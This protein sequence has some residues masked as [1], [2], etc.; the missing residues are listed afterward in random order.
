MKRRCVHA[1]SR[2]FFWTALLVTL[3][4]GF[5]PVFWVHSG[6]VIAGIDTPPTVDYSVLWKT[7]QNTWDPAPNGGLS[8]FVGYGMFMPYLLLGAV[9]QHVGLTTHGISTGALCFVFGAGALGMVLLAR[10]AGFLVAGLLGIAYTLNFA[11]TFL[12]PG[13]GAFLSY[14]FLPWP[15]VAAT[16]AAGRARL[17]QIAIGLVAGIGTLFLLYAKINP[18]T[19]VATWLGAALIV[20]VTLRARGGRAPW[21]F[22]CA[23]T[24]SAIVCNL[25]WAVDF[26]L[27][28]KLD[29]SAVTASLNIQS[30]S[31]FSSLAQVLLLGGSWALDGRFDADPYFAYAPYYRADIVQVLLALV[32]AG[33]IGMLLAFYRRRAALLLLCS[34][35]VLAAIDAGYHAPLGWL[36]DWTFTHVPGFWL[37]REPLTKFDG[38]LAALY[39]TA[40]AA[41]LPQLQPAVQRRFASILL[42]ITLVGCIAG[43]VPLLNGSV[44]RPATRHSPGYAV[45]VPAYWHDFGTW[46]NDQQG[47]RIA[48]LPQNG[49]YQLLYDWGY[50][51]SDI[52]GYVLRHPYVDV[53]PSVGYTDSPLKTAEQMWYRNLAAEG[54]DPQLEMR[55]SDALDIQYAVVRHDVI[56]SGLSPTLVHP[57]VYVPRLLA[58]KF[59]LVRRFGRLDV[60][61]RACCIDAAR[62]L[63]AATNFEAATAAIDPTFMPSNVSFSAAAMQPPAGYRMQK[64]ASWFKP[65]EQFAFGLIGI[66]EGDFAGVRPDSALGDSWN[67]RLGLHVAPGADAFVGIGSA[68]QAIRNGAAV[69]WVSDPDTKTAEGELLTA[70]PIASNRGSLPITGSALTQLGQGIV[71]VEGSGATGKVHF[72]TSGDPAHSIEPHQEGWL[73]PRHSA[74]FRTNLT[75]PFTISMD[76]ESGASDAAVTVRRYAVVDDQTFVVSPEA[77]QPNG[78]GRTGFGR[79]VLRLNRAASIACGSDSC[80]FA[81]GALHLHT[82]RTVTASSGASCLPQC[83]WAAFALDSNGSYR[84]MENG[85]VSKKGHVFQ[86]AL[87]RGTYALGLLNDSRGASPSNLA[88]VELS[89]AARVNVFAL[90]SPLAR[91]YTAEASETSARGHYDAQEPQALL[92]QQ[93]YSNGWR[94]YVDG[95]EMPHAATVISEN[96]WLVP[97]GRHD[98]RLVFGLQ[99]IGDALQHVAEIWAMLAAVA[100]IALWVV[101]RRRT[102]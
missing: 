4:S 84:P 23:F 72:D 37:F 54:Y 99:P 17:E 26:A 58:M 30:V 65:A 79:V 82:A 33:V 9:L 47:G 86:I 15:A 2:R 78:R 18:P 29:A 48:M 45:S 90:R 59:S 63:L 31:D 13:F 83:R 27:G 12:A 64:I 69:E 56:P 68:L 61:R 5:V 35:V 51:G 50:L 85:A 94:L 74:V 34:I 25:W 21:A 38:V 10:R 75:D 14:A 49:H 8:N 36:F 53:T 22:F 70:T 1:S 40:F 66:R 52:D 77:L 71:V 96:L 73:A 28:L 91:V 32:P 3:A 98:F 42:G 19:Y 93:S 80:T 41:L 67:E 62:P 44:I 11:H 46:A 100:A 60:Y 57:D 7:T 88:F 55:L 6:F 20:A 39:V 16:Y 43:G 89:G 24:V 97:A 87:P 101:S 95:K 102:A 81:F 92:L 76:P